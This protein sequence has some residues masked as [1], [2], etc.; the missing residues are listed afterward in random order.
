MEGGEGMVAVVRG[1]RDSGLA[2]TLLDGSRQY[3]LMPNAAKPPSPPNVRITHT[4]A[5]AQ[6]QEMARSDSAAQAT[7][8]RYASM[9]KMA[10]CRVTPTSPPVQ[11]TEFPPQRAELCPGHGNFEVGGC[12]S[13]ENYTPC[14]S[15]G[16]F[17]GGMSWPD[18]VEEVELLQTNPS[19]S[20]I[21][22]QDGRET[23]VS[24][25]HLAPLPDGEDDSCQEE[26][27]DLDEIVQ[28]SES[29]QQ[30]E[31]G[32]E[33]GV[34]EEPEANLSRRSHRARRRPG[35]LEDF[36]CDND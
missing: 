20:Y 31:L 30:P 13:G 21:R 3:T 4:C 12:G 25:R 6:T 7:D 2:V 26:P 29:V 34:A 8:G 36:V 9:Y 32:Q 24:N 16:S 15:N 11:L 27:S 22:L 23:T 14:R 10:H 33:T 19:Y 35:Y 17:R 28:E 1:L 18:R 5:R